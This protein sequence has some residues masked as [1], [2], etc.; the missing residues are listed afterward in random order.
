M[1]GEGTVKCSTTIQTGHKI[2]TQKTL[3]ASGTQICPGFKSLE[4]RKLCLLIM[5]CTPFANTTLTLN[6]ID[7]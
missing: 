7:F 5:D 3:L 6:M 2:I 4:T 1:A